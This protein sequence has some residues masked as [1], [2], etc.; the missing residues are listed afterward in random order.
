M[1][2]PV[3]CMRSHALRVQSPVVCMKNAGVKNFPQVTFESSLGQGMRVYMGSMLREALSFE[4]QAIN[5]V[6]QRLPM[7]SEAVTERKP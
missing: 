4:T 5:R 3:V 6:N 7:R 1:Q 2:V